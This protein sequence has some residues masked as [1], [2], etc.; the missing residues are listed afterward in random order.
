MKQIWFI[1]PKLLHFSTSSIGFFPLSSNIIFC[2]ANLQYGND[3]KKDY[4]SATVNEESMEFGNQMHQLSL[5]QSGMVDDI[6]SCN[7]VPVTVQGWKG[8]YFVFR[9]ENWQSVIGRFGNNDVRVC[10]N[11]QAFY[12][13]MTRV[14]ETAH[15]KFGATVPGVGLGRRY[16]TF[17]RYEWMVGDTIVAKDTNCGDLVLCNQEKIPM[18]A[19]SKQ[20]TV[21]AIRITNNSGD[22]RNPSMSRNYSPQSNEELRK[23][24]F[25][26]DGVSLRSQTLA[27]SHGML[28][29]VPASDD[30][31]HIEDGVMHVHVTENGW[32]QIRPQVDKQ[33]HDLIGEQPDKLFHHVL[34]CLPR[35]TYPG[36]NPVASPGEIGFGEYSRM[37]DFA[38]GSISYLMHEFGH[39]LNLKH[40]GTGGLKHQ[41]QD[42]SGYM[43][44][45][46]NSQDF[47]KLCYNGLNHYRLK[48]YVNKLVKLDKRIINRYRTKLVAYTE[49]DNAE[50]DQAL[51]IQAGARIISFNAAYGMNKDTRKGKNAVLVHGGD[52][53]YAD[54]LYKEVYAETLH[55]VSDGWRINVHSIH[56]DAQ[57]P[58]AD[59]TM[60]R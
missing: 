52:K 24:I 59:V 25:G 60:Y 33:V 21:L 28:E 54:R 32:D 9:A 18:R 41:Y 53:G 2:D 16:P 48:W 15:K 22:T 58:Y 20:R 42:S 38:C 4:I 46:W 51:A 7:A 12:T 27:C 40:A 23:W 11:G 56:L 5:V 13:G 30:S 31:G 37:W 17:K 10:R 57:P 44:G 8:D 50:F 3:Q 45:G 26:T 35:S 34:Y 6:D 19:P 49:Y 36:G 43:G 47:P 1:L 29:Y 39:N 55:Y 14:W